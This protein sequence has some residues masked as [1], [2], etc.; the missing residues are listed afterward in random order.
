MSCYLYSFVSNAPMRSV[1]KSIAFA[2]CSIYLNISV[3]AE[4]TGTDTSA[5]LDTVIVTANRLDAAR[6][7]LSPDTGSSVYHI[8]AD[9]IKALPLGDATPMN[10][11]I[12]QAPGVVQDSFG[13]LHIRGDHANLQYRINGVIIPEA[14]TGF[15]QSLDMRAAN[16]ISILTGALPAQYGYRTAGI[17]DIHTK[18]YIPDSSGNVAITGGNHNDR[19][20]GADY[21]GSSSSFAYSLIGSY[22]QNDLG[23]ENPTASQNA[24]HDHTEQAKGFGYLSYILDDNSRLNF[25]FGLSGNHFEIPNT[26]GLNCMTNDCFALNSVNLSSIDA[27]RF[28]ARQNEQNA[29]EALSYQSK[30]T[31]NIDYQVSLFHRDSSVHYFPDPVGDLVFNGI[32]ATIQR[33]DKEIGLQADISYQLND[34]HKLRGG[35]FI[36]SERFTVNNQSLVFAVDA[37]GNQSSDIP[38]NINDDSHISGHTGGVYL[39]DEWQPT[40]K[41]TIN[42]GARF[43]KINTVVNEQQFSPR[44][45]MVYDLSPDTH[46]HIG[47]ARYFTPPS[48]EKIDTT[49]IAKFADTTNA[50]PSDANTA[51]KS[52]RSHYFDIGV[53]QEVNKHLIVG[54]DTYYR[55]VQ[56]LQDDG[57]FGNA[58]IFSAFNYAE[59]RVYGAELTASYNV[60]KLT[61]YTNLAYSVAQARNVQTG[62]FNFDPNELSYIADHWVYVDHDQRVAGSAG[63][64]YTWKMTQLS[65]DLLYGSGLRRGFA[66]L[67]KLPP[68]TQINFAVN[69][70][71]NS[72]G[73]GKLTA[74]LALLNVFDK[75]YE[76]RDGSGI[77]VGAPQ[78]GP[79][80][81]IYVSLS[82]AF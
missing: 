40:T 64:S 41:L 62:Q 67:E 54:L 18:G 59:G 51:V 30:A 35:L 27:T 68:Y 57:Q 74:K 32:G 71:F 34:N 53:S 28:D 47:Y 78:F 38:I 5:N 20:F 50:L 37:N 49:T 2:L 3:A 73:I 60:D 39:Q 9:D 22:L 61:L 58:L 14:I 70:S 11:A 77:G 45:G 24:V 7:G 31:D 75:S 55:K 25:M 80:R 19:E 17:V 1:T 16:Q 48:T 43:D 72:P 46:L 63:M 42:Y 44:L 4:S 15:G 52:E 12:L 23:I 81:S 66:N 10:Q 36:S 26:P 21:T 13:Q 29:F 6:N 65:A 69:R 82:K 79:R 8:G 33:Q 76:L 56:N